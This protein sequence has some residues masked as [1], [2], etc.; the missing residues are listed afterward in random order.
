M[1][2]YDLIVENFILLFFFSLGVAA[3]F[4]LDSL[5][6]TLDYDVLTFLPSSFSVPLQNLSLVV[7][8]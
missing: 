4:V 1:K 7:S 5:I 6:K 3:L 2:I 8:P